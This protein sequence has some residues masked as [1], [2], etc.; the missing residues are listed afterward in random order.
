M[1]ISPMILM[2]AAVLLLAGKCLIPHGRFWG[3]VCL[4]SLAVSACGML[5]SSVSHE[6][7]AAT[8]VWAA[9]A[10]GFLLA[11]SSMGEHRFSINS[12]ERYAGLLTALAGLMWAGA[13]DDLITLALAL[14]LISFSTCLTLVT[15]SRL[16]GTSETVMKY[17]L[18]NVLSTGLLWFGFALLYGITGTTNLAECLT[19]L[20][21]GTSLL[22][23]EMTV[24]VGM[25]FSL[26]AVVLVVA[27]LGMR[28]PLVPFQFGAP[29]LAAATSTWNAALLATIPK[30]TVLIVM[31]RLF[32]RSWNELEETVPLLVLV[33]AGTTMTAAAI[34]ALRETRIR[35]ILAYTT[36]AHG[37]FALIGIA[38]GSAEAASPAIDAMPG[39]SLTSGMTAGLFYLAGYLFSIIGLLA[40]LCYLA[41]PDG[42]VEYVED[43]SGL[44]RSEP[45][46]AGCALV[47]LLSLAGLPPL[48]V[49]LGNLLLTMSA[50]AAPMGGESDSLPLMHGGFMA[51]AF[52]AAVDLLL[53]GAVYL[54]MVANICTRDQIGRPRPTGGRAALLAAVIAA[55]LTVGVG[56]FPAPLLEQLE[57]VTRQQDEF[58]AGSR[59]NKLSVPS[60][61]V[62][63]IVRGLQE[64]LDVAGG[65]VAVDGDAQP[66]GMTHGVDVFLVQGLMNLLDPRVPKRHNAG[67]TV[68]FVGREHFD[69]QLLQSF[70]ASP[71]QRTAV[72]IDG[73]NSNRLNVT[74]P[75][76]DR[77]HGRVIGH[78]H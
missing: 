63:C 50:L 38:V 1:L 75:G 35:H 70:D 55:V 40:V 5:T 74:Q 37:G 54:R 62:Q 58:A 39:S 20:S 2:A 36:I 26:V 21:N 49:S 8:V 42:D 61:T 19:I 27:G 52:V 44:F 15:S 28:M 72:T 57:R 14:E 60:D 16:G 67:E 51:L 10:T 7:L 12:A 6:P 47:C 9:L 17:L 45:I 34:M 18:L 24:D 46:A 33:V 3:P 32:G 31:F 13:A 41:R 77:I 22:E 43:L 48:P 66:A 53:L 68:G 30:T 29:E 69:R 59:L 76:I 78:S 71:H 64:P 56:L 25:R 23:P 4:L 65:V 73:L 11:L